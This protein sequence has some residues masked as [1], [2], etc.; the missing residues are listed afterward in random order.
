ML[1]RLR[2]VHANLELFHAMAQRAHKGAKNRPDEGNNLLGKGA[3]N[4]LAA[5][6]R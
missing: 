5:E 2:L 3:K 1:F 6:R 4:N